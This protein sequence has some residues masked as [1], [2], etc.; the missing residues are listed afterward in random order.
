MKSLRYIT[1]GYGY[2]DS[3]KTLT[4]A[5]DWLAHN[6][7]KIFTITQSQRSYTIFYWGVKR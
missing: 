5:L 1:T 7:L 6:K 4:K 3:F 2:E